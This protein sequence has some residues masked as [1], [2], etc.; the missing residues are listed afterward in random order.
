MRASE[1]KAGYSSVIDELLMRAT[2]NRRRKM[3]SSGVVFLHDNGWPHTAA[4]TQ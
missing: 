3:L 4:K 1:I 2:Q